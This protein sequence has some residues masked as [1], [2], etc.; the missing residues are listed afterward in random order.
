LIVRALRALL[1]DPLQVNSGVI[2][3]YPTAAHTYDEPRLRA[4]LNVLPQR[5]RTAFA[6]ACVL[7]LLR[8]VTEA[9][10]FIVD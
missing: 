4:A 3:P 2:R 5:E 10:L 6:I 1:F 9:T 8:S 7:R